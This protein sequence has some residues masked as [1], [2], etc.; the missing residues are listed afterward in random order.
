MLHVLLIIAGYQANIYLF[1]V[2]PLS[3]N[4][5]TKPTNCLSVFDHF[6]GLALKWFNIETLENNKGFFLWILRKF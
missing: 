4:P 2:N 3:T 1:E 5:T 6:T